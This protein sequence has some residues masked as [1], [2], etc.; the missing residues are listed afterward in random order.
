M[1]GFN[2]LLTA[3]V[4]TSLLNVCNLMK[5]QCFGHGIT[6]FVSTIITYFF[7]QHLIFIDNANFGASATIFGLFIIVTEILSDGLYKN[8]KSCHMIVTHVMK[9]KPDRSKSLENA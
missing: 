1:F 2:P 7:S 6:L 9:G 4:K 8:N 3:K 5:K